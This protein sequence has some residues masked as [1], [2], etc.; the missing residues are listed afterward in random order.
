[1]VESRML[2]GVFSGL[3][4][5]YGSYFDDMQHRSVISPRG[6]ATGIQQINPN[7]L[8]LDKFPRHKG[9]KLDTSSGSS[10]SNYHI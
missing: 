7:H 5:L 4:N 8:Q 9:G 6:G 3:E 1:M 10:K 2:Q